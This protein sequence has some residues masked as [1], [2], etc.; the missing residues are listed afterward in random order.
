[1]YTMVVMRIAFSVP[2]HEAPDCIEDLIQNVLYYVP[3]GGHDPI[4]MLHP[5]PSIHATCQE[6]AMRYSGRVY[7]ND[8]PTVKEYD[9]YSFFRSYIENFEWMEAHGIRADVFI[10]FPSK[11][12]FVRPLRLKGFENRLTLPREYFMGELERLPHDWCNRVRILRNPRVLDVLYKHGIPITFGQQEG[13]TVEWHVMRQVVR[14]VRTH[15][16]E[17]LVDHHCVFEEVLP[18][19]L[20]TF[21]S[22]KAP[23][24]TCRVMW[25]RPMTSLDDVKYVESGGGSG[26]REG[27]AKWLEVYGDTCAVKPILRSY[28]DPL[29]V[30]IR[31]RANMYRSI[32]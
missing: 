6:L 12:L 23:Y 26:G 30:Y 25:D 4:V 14:F 28:N 22:G 13:T 3:L 31:E 18:H 29:R 7:V 5:S 20:C 32:S 9:H 19:S 16:L 27:C 21:F 11:C 17:S 8:T 10:F 24:Y 15:D 2:V 1:M